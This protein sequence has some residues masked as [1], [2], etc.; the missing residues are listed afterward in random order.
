MKITPT[1]QPSTLAW[2]AHYAALPH[3]LIVVDGLAGP[4][5]GGERVVLK[6]ASL[7]PE[8]GY[9]V[10]ILTFQGPTNPE[11][12]ANPPCP[13]YVIP[14]TS[15]FNGTALRAAFQL[16]QFLRDQKVAIVQ[17]FFESS[18]LWAGLIT[19]TM[20]SA[21]L[22]WSRRDMGILRRNKHRLAYRVLGG[23][24]DRVF[25]V[26]ELVRKHCIEVDRIKSE[27]VETIY[28]GIDLAKWSSDR[29]SMKAGAQ[30]V[31]TT[32]G[33]I[34]YVKGHDVFVRAAA[35]IAE[36]YP[37][38]AFSI[39]GVILDPDYFKDLQMLIR[40]L[41]LTDRFHFA[42]GVHDLRSH[43]G[44]AD[45]FVL[46]SRSEGFSNAI[47]EA[48]AMS[49]PVVATGVGGNAEAVLDGI[50]GFIVPTE[51][52]DALAEA[53]LRLL[54]DPDRARKMGEAGRQLVV[55]RFTITAMMTR[56]IQ[57]YSEVLA[58]GLHRLAPCVP[59]E[60][61]ATAS[62]VEAPPRLVL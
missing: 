19:K 27:R 31:I 56:V 50:S 34:R 21:K 36:R 49:L 10:S 28:N 26:A 30:V 24:P 12:C 1:L 29:F 6:L 3:V 5:G 23:L 54:D 58:G 44:E 14:L 51:N 25:A 53:I 60:G 32:V 41:G 37:K 45:I 43:F 8:Y 40:E 16:G 22:I 48:M 4:M 47:V 42:G 17:T 18:D 20:S 61:N 38:A 35:Q 15:A 52:P 39:A 57:A 33:N 2:P 62:Q 59:M 46:P 13:I 7:L 9:R 11:V 55:E